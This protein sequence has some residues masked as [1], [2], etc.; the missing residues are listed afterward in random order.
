MY[1]NS[2]ISG[3]RNLIKKEGEKILKYKDLAIRN[4]THLESKK[5]K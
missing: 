3:D 5:Q 2:A 4:T 1:V